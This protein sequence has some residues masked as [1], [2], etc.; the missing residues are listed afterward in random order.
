MA[1]ESVTRQLA[2]LGGDAIHRE[3]II[4]DNGC[5][6]LDVHNLAISNPI[7]IETQI[8]QMV[9]TVSNGLFAQRPADLMLLGTADG[10]RIIYP[11]II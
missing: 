8:N 9:G 6:I 5:D 7:A 3:G 10:V 11:S 1:R 4:T 2:A